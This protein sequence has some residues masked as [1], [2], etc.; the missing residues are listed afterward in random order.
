MEVS[1][2]DVEKELFFAEKP[3]ISA[4]ILSFIEL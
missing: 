2:Y 1:G 4:I 3:K